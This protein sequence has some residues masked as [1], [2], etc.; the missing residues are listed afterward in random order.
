VVALSLAIGDV[1]TVL[2]LAANVVIAIGLSPSVWLARRVP[3]W[4]WPAYG[5]VVGL[6]VAWIALLFTLL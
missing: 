5:V 2:A 6:P 1:S 3:V 4:R